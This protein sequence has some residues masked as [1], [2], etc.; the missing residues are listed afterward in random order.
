MRSNNAFTTVVVPQV[1]R[2][3]KPQSFLRSVR[4]ETMMSSLLIRTARCFALTTRKHLFVVVSIQGCRRGGIDNISEWNCMR[5]LVHNLMDVI[6]GG[7]EGSY[8]QATKVGVGVASFAFEGAHPPPVYVGQLVL[9]RTVDAAVRHFPR[10][11][12]L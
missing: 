3:G 9:K 7:D 6:V 12:P 10:H 11:L 5:E 8:M 4:D 1:G 2:L